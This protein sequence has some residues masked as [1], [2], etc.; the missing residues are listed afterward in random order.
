MRVFE[1]SVRE[2]GAEGGEV[3]IVDWDEKMIEVGRDGA[4]DTSMVGLTGWAAVVSRM[5]LS[6]SE[7]VKL[8]S[9]EGI[10]QFLQTA[11]GFQLFFHFLQ[12][13]CSEE[14][15]TFYQEASGLSGLEARQVLE[16]LVVM[17]HKYIQVTAPRCI[18]VSGQLRNQIFASLDSMGL[19]EKVLEQAAEDPSVLQ[20]LQI[21]DKDLPRL[22][23]V[24]EKARM[25]VFN[26]LLVPVAPR[27]L[28]FL[29]SST[30]AAAGRRTSPRLAAKAA[31][32]NFGKATTPRISSRYTPYQKSRSGA[33][34][35][36]APTPNSEQ[37]VGPFSVRNRTR[38]LGASVGD[39]RNTFAKMWTPRTSS[40]GVSDELPGLDSE[41]IMEDD[42]LSRS[43]SGRQLGLQRSRSDRELSRSAADC[44]SPHNLPQSPGVA[45]VSLARMVFRESSTPKSHDKE[46]P[47]LVKRALRQQNGLDSPAQP[48]RTNE[49]Q[50]MSNEELDFML[51][52]L[53]VLQ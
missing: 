51:D 47:M 45:R 49:A 16:S 3:E 32:G 22:R 46:T 6:Q 35:A 5:S 24:L 34:T 9:P 20:R 27:F 53:S 2:E 36:S 26:Q 1:I 11:R 4:V 29:K 28:E 14:N 18:N 38:K 12:K 41:T 31:K 21:G 23:T 48:R 19:S 15:L 50:T 52:Q 42:A 7:R 43:G 13:E 44:N 39:A 30:A 33:T 17:V 25:E 37:E 40:R 8:E 10:Q